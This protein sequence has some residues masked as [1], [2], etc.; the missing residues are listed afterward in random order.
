VMELR[1]SIKVG[2]RVP[3]ELHRAAVAKSH[4]TGVPMSFEVRCALEQW[5]AGKWIPTA[6]DSVS[7]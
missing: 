6:A 5:V 3:P 1:N 7:A 4:R 2:A